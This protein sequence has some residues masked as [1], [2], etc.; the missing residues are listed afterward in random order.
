MGHGIR[1]N[2]LPRHMPAVA[3]LRWRGM[4]TKPFVRCTVLVEP[5]TAVMIGE[6]IVSSSISGMLIRMIGQ[7]MFVSNKWGHRR[8]P[9]LQ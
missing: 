7:Q 9:F 3:E 8:A 1:G 6:V 4:Q 2:L 5:S